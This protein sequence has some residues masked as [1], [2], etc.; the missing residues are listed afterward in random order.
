MDGSEALVSREEDAIL[1]FE[2]AAAELR[3]LPQGYS[4]YVG[5]GTMC[6]MRGPSHDENA[7]PLHDNVVTIAPKVRIDG[8][9]W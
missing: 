2:R 9:D 3:K 7:R 4:V 5:G 1:H 6:L 8:G